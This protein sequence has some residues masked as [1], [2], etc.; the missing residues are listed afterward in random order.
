M[1]KISREVA[2][3]AIFVPKTREDFLKYSCDLTFDPNTAN[4]ELLLSEGNKRVTRRKWEDYPDHPDRFIGHAQ[5]LCEQG[6]SRRVYWE[7][8]LE[9]EKF[10]AGIAVVYKSISA[11]GNFRTDEKAW[12]LQFTGKE[13]SFWHLGEKT[14]ISISPTSRIGVY[15]DYRA[16]TLS[17]YNVS[18]SMTLLHSVNIT[19]TE[20]IYPGFWVSSSLKLCS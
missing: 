16:G 5:V 8:E 4:Q 9:Q 18:D 1:I 20:S 12:C 19:F 6:F 3:V 15:V 2:S 14:E 17:F 11:K 7:V 10:G 13:C